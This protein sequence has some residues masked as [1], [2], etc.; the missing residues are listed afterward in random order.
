VRVIDYLRLPIEGDTSRPFASDS[1]SALRAA[2]G[3]DL[4]PG[5][6]SG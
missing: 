5:G 1:L 3:E 2:H 4:V 6:S